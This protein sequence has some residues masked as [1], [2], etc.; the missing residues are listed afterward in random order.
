VSADGWSPAQYD[1]FRAERR[2]PFADL[3]ALVRP[4]PHP[5][6]VDLGCGTGEPTAE[7]HDRLAAAETV[8]LDTSAEMLAQAAA[9]S[10]PGLRFERRSIEDYAAA[11]GSPVDVVFSNAAFHWVPDHEALFRRL[12]FAL[13]PGG[14]LAVQMPANDDQPAHRA[15]L[16]VADEAPFRDA[17]GDEGRRRSP[18]LAPEAYAVLLDRLGFA[19]QHVRL[20]VYGHQ[21]ESREAVV[22]WMKGAALTHYRERLPPE[23]FERFLDAYRER[24]L[25]VLPDARPV[26]FPYKRLLL[27]GR[28]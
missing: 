4:A 14:Q 16:E 17:L 13:V 1:R 2:Q 20:Q 5:R 8:G 3:L 26:F 15:A 28:R 25:A 27:W 19:Q 24:V 18:V 11:P 10:R 6:V 9:L 23:L 21:L 22:E 12:C 7:L